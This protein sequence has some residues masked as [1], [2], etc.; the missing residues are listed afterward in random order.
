MVDANT[1]AAARSGDGAARTTIAQAFDERIRRYLTAMVGDADAAS[2]LTQSTFVR[3]FDKLGDLRDDSKLS[4]WLYSIAINLCRAWL[5]KKVD[6]DDRGLSTEPVAPRASVLSSVVR[7]ESAE[8]VALAVDRLPIL[9]REAFVLHVVEGH[10]YSEIAA[11][12]GA[13]VE[14]LHVRAHRAK[15]LL[16]KQIGSVVDTFWSEP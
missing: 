10:P 6:S 15:G 12:T 13:T 11:M 16:R 9:L 8:A 2:D 4:S 7:R 1:V 14:A 3:A 5:K